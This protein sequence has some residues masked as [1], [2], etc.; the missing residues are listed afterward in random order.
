MKHLFSVIVVSLLIL[1]AASAQTSPDLFVF[2]SGTPIKASEVNANFQLLRDQIA[3]AIGAGNVTLDD[4]EALAATVDKLQTAFESGDLDG[5]SL[6]YE[7][8]GSRLGVRQVGE[9]DYAYVDLRGPAGPAGSAG[10]DGAAGADGVDGT[11]GANGADGA[12]GLPGTPGADGEDGAPGAAGADGA[13]GADGADGRG[14]EYTWNDTQL[15]I[16]YEG[17]TSYTFVELVGATGLQGAEGDPGA[18]GTNGVDGTDGVDGSDGADGRTLLNGSGGPSA[19]L[20]VDGDFYIDTANWD[21]YGPKAPGG[22]GSSSSLIGPQGPKGDAG[23]GGG[24]FGSVRIDVSNHAT[25]LGPWDEAQAFEVSCQAGEVL[26]D[27]TVSGESHIYIYGWVIGIKQ[28][29]AT[30]SVVEMAMDPSE[31]VSFTLYTKCLTPAA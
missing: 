12:D 20:G 29:S 22:W 3:E 13:P 23:S 26:L 27:V 30:T 25:D 5:L 24:G 15:G 8:N 11:D 4:L 6:E 1:P 28:L 19:A 21:I 31:P 14:I 7:W 16:R 2:E 17:E 9:A 18:P 10:A